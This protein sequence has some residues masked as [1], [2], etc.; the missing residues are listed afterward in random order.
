MNKQDLLKGFSDEDERLVFAKVLDQ[1]EFCMKRR[2]PAFSVFMDRAKCAR[3]LERMKN[4]RD[5]EVIA[6]GGMED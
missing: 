4:F 2:S 3:F 6:F 1:A 5:V